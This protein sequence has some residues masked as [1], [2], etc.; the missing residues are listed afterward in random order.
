MKKFLLFAMILFI[1]NE[2]VI[3]QKQKKNKRSEAAFYSGLYR[4][5][6]REAGYSQKDID[7]KVD[8]AFHDIFEG[9]QKIYFEVGDSMAYVSD[10]KNHDARTEGLSYGMMIAVQMNKKNVFDRIWRWSKKYLQHTDG[11][12]EGYFAWSI[13]PQTMKR[14]SEGTASDGELYFITSLLFASNR[15]GNNTGI[16]YY[17]EARRILDAMWKKDGTGGIFNIINTEHKQITF[18]PEGNNDNFTDPS[19]Q[20]PA[21][22]E[23]WALYANDGHEQFYKDCADTA[24]A[25]L[26]RACDAPTGL[27]ADLTDFDGKPLARGRMQPAFRYDSWRVPMNIAMDYN[28][29]GKDKNWQQDYAKRFQDFLKSKG[30][31][32][33]EDQFNIDGSRPEFILPAGG[34]RKLRHSLGLIATAA[35]TEIINKDDFA[36]VH[37]LW[38]AKLEPYDD[39]YFDPYY[40]GLL[41]LFSLMHLSGKYQLIKPLSH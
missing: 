13:N 22:F 16:D 5:V 33:F 14:N 12:R 10:L 21:F 37:A 9:P 8:K 11:P 38:N 26:H 6:F 41:Y 35:S 29:F 40:D 17:H 20:L 3:A 15:W 28:W 31:D 32:S 19:Y 1:A 24:R 27:N 30:I 18:T 34:V 25:F 39:G 7:A 2:S 4:N 36:F 23:V